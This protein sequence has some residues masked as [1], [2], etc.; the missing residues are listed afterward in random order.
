MGEGSAFVNDPYVAEFQD[1]A[2]TIRQGLRTSIRSTTTRS[3]GSGR[4]PA[5]RTSGTP[6]SHPE[7]ER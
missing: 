1:R 5:S 3:G 2:H 4:S 7:S 6:P